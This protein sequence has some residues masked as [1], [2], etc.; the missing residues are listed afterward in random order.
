MHKPVVAVLRGGPSSEYDVSLQSG[1]VILQHMPEK[2]QALDVLI[3]K[4][5]AWHVAGVPRGIEYVLSRSDVVFNALHGEFGEDGQV[6]AILDAHHAKYTG[7]RRIGAALAMN[8]ALSKSYFK[9]HGLL[10]PGHV[11]IYPN[12]AK[13][14]VFNIFRTYT[15][16]LV[17]KPV[18]AGSSV[19]IV[20]AKSFKSFSDAVFS[21]LEVWPEV[22]VEEYI[23]GTELTCGVIENFRGQSHYATLPVEVRIPKD[24]QFFD[25]DAKYTGITEELCP[26]RISLSDKERVQQAAI[27]A[28]KAISAGQYSR[29]D[30]ILSPKGLYI[31]ETNT[32]PGLTEESLLPKPLHAVGCS[33]THFIEHLVEDARRR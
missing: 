14:K 9:Q 4:S 6:Q 27:V 18:G 25:Y 7:P 2:Y 16:P 15:L 8:K 20:L 19:G 22:I 24:K 30:F 3:D 1:K 29:A 10:V 5:G 17:V 23:G 28:H 21:S 32:L 13:E 11:H 31:I 26:A 12:D 33:M